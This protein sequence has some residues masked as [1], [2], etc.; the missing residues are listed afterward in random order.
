MKMLGRFLHA[1]LCLF[2]DASRLFGFLVFV[3][4]AGLTPAAAGGLI[5]ITSAGE[6]DYPPF[7]T[8]DDEGNLTGFSIELLQASLAAMGREASFQTGIWA[9]VRGLLERGEVEVLPLV[10]RT[11]ER[12]NLFDFT[13][14][15]MVLHGAIV[16]RDDTHDVSDLRSLSGRRVA[17][18]RGDNM[19]EFLHREKR[20]FEICLTDTYAQ[21][22]EGLANGLY[23]AVLIQHLLALRL[24]QELGLSNLLVVDQLLEGFAQEFCFAVKEGDA[25]NLAMLNEGLAIAVAN[26]T[27]RH[28]HAKWF[29][30]MELPVH[31][32]IVVGGDDR[33]P[34]FEFRDER[35]RPAGY[36]VDL[37]R[38][39]AREMGLDVTIRLGP[40]ADIVKAFEEGE[41]D[42]LQGLF[43]TTKRGLKFDFSQT[44]SVNHYVG[45]VRRGEEAPPENLLDLVGK[46]VVVQQ[47]SAIEDMLRDNGLADQLVMVGSEEAVLSALAEGECDCA[48]APRVSTLYF[49]DRMGLENLEVGKRPFASMDYCY[50]VRRGQQALLAEFNEGLRVVEASGEYRRIYDEWLGVYE[51]HPVSFMPALRLA[52]FVLVPLLLVLLVVVLW[53]WSLRRRVAARTSELRESMDRFR[54]LAESAPVGIVIFSS[55]NKTIHV[56][57]Q[58]TRLC[59]YTLEDIP[60]ASDWWVCAYPDEEQRRKVFNVWRESF[61]TQKENGLEIA[62]MDFSITCKNG[63]VLQ[64]ELRLASTPEWYFAIFTDVTDQRRLEARLRQSEKI[65]AVGRLAG[66]VA[67]DYNNMLGIIIGFAEL[68]L[69]DVGDNE[70]VRSSLLEIIKAGKR[71]ADITRQL[72]AFA[73]KQTIRP[74]PLDLNGAIEGM[75]LMLRRLIGEHVDLGWVPGANL[76]MVHMDPSQIHQIL[77]NLCVNARDAISGSG[78]IMVET[79][80]VTLD[81]TFCSGHGEVAPGEYVLLLVSDD[82]HGMDQEVREN[83]FEPFFTTKAVN[84]GTGLGLAMVYGAVKQNNGFITVYSEVG[85]G[86]CFKIYLPKYTG[87]E[88]APYVEPFLSTPLGKG[89]TV[90]LVEDE[91]AL[92]ELTRKMLERMG[93]QVLAAGTPREALELAREPCSKIQLLLTDVVMPEMS[94]REL[95]VQMCRTCPLLR[96]LYMS[97]YTSNMITSQGVL[98]DGVHFIQKPLTFQTLA[99]KVREVLETSEQQA[100]GP[101]Q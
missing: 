87:K 4:L 56:S 15:Y 73:R 37:T 66:G 77:V 30:E 54:L 24:I 27:H 35:G 22:L 11:P 94:G 41:I 99:A 101:C 18:M 52:M 26:G 58:F 46:K 67:H 88:Q 98:D 9:N 45:V 20:D 31:R 6:V 79:T 86:A 71:S 55:G 50:A 82:G 78:K 59:G 75:L 12:E 100:G 51:K 93:Y 60:T 85:R 76:W 38:A 61:E 39:I 84:E 3:A 92:L 68:G 32:R 13:V 65:E 21:A 42:V 28:L 7:C 19:E 49:I 53:V 95:A 34:P 90:L 83:L 69:D 17:V 64:T 25:Q 57:R 96:V 10:G 36:N 97:G 29:A 80:N 33:Y 16:V 47:G 62:P 63:A 14:P 89:E 81:A 5:P 44:H 91:P 70:S 23:D 72:L 74:T 48:L 8:L 1:G 43:Y 2:G 40:W